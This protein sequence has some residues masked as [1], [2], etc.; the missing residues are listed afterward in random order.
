MKTLMVEKI[1]ILTRLCY[2]MQE[3]IEVMDVRSRV[4]E[5]NQEKMFG[6]TWQEPRIE[7]EFRDATM[8]CDEKRIGTP[9]VIVT[10]QDD[11]LKHCP[12]KDLMERESPARID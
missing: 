3:K 5:E 2:I 1:E 7:N 8:A 11:L 9:T 12:D 4:I 10:Q 6:K